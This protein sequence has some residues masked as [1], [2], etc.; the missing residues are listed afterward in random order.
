[1][2]R[3]SEYADLCPALLCSMPYNTPSSSPVE[4]IMVAW[5][6]EGFRSIRELSL[7]SIVLA[8]A[9]TWQ[10]W[11]ETESLSWSVSCLQQHPQSHADLYSTLSCAGWNQLW[12]SF[13]T[14]RPSRQSPLRLGY[15]G[16]YRPWAITGPPPLSL[17][18]SHGEPWAG[19]I[20]YV[21]PMQYSQNSTAANRCYCA[22]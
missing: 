14:G 15:T 11:Q 22:I 9:P 6:L 3:E 4:G 17:F 5:D 7:V 12:G 1:M 2:Q 20:T 10:A 19:S 21:P 18:S 8:R 16:I 13:A